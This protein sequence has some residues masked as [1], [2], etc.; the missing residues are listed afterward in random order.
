MG[1]GCTFCSTVSLQFGCWRDRRE[2]DG[3]FRDFGSA[4]FAW[5]MLWYARGKEEMRE[6]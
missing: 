1:G 2:G 6:K 3:L 4:N 5:S